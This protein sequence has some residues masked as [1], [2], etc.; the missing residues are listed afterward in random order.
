MFDRFNLDYFAT[1]DR[2]VQLCEDLDIGIEMIMEGWGFEFPF[3]HRALFTA[4][5]E[6]LWMRYL[7]ARYDAYNC[8]Y[9]WTP[10][11]EY[12]YYPNGDLHPQA[13]GR[14][15]GDPDRP[16]DQ[17]HGTARPC[18][19]HAQR[20][21]PAALRRAVQRRPRGGRR[22]LLP[23][24]G[25]ARRGAGLA[26]RR[27]RGADPGRP[28]RLARRR[29]VRRMGL[30]AQPGLRAQAAQPRV[31]RPQPHPPRRLARRLLRHGHHHRLRE[32]LGAVDGPGRGPARPRRSPPPPALHDRARAVGQA[33][34][35][36]G[37]AGRE[38]SPARPAGRPCWRR[39][40][41]MSSRPICRS[42]AASGSPC[43]PAMP[44]ALVR[45]AHRCPG[46]CARPARCGLPI[47]ADQQPRPAPGRLGPAGRP[48]PDFSS[49][50]GR[51]VTHAFRTREAQPRHHQHRRQERGR[52]PVRHRPRAA[53]AD[54]RAARHRPGPFRQHQVGAQP[55]GQ[56]RRGHAPAAPDG[57]RGQGHRG[58]RRGGA[59][60]RREHARCPRPVPS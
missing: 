19:R 29:G 37:A 36:A 27:H 28:R 16:L 26:R 39:P 48:P 55:P 8:L 22:H 43:R 42:A 5:W 35:G 1:V 45:S 34:A 57:A 60:P 17:G 15:L 51:R 13:G 14:P 47:A 4:E 9:F 41:A 6:E 23:G 59:D 40:S 7:I 25:D 3:N 30:R 31:L 21:A 12:E 52:R 49:T 38:R 53:D 10:L 18:R 33:R 24:M 56:P 50:S 46:G 2:V 32:L 44:R 20:A 54:L 11:N 58:R